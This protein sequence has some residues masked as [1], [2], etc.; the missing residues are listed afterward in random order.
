MLKN[1]LVLVAAA[2]LLFSVLLVHAINF[3]IAS[4]Q[5]PADPASVGDV[6]MRFQVTIDGKVIRPISL[7]KG[8]TPFQAAEQFCRTHGLMQVTKAEEDPGVLQLEA[9]LKARL[10]DYTIDEDDEESMTFIKVELD[11]QTVMLQHQPGLDPFSESR[12]F[13]EMKGFQE[14]EL[15]SCTQTL[16]EALRARMQ[17]N[18]QSEVPQDRLQ[19]L[20]SLPLMLKGKPVQLDYFVRDTP[21]ESAYQF[22]V[23][24]GLETDPDFTGYLKG[25]TAGI[26]DRLLRYSEETAAIQKPAMQTF[27]IPIS[28]NGVDTELAFA[29][30]QSAIEAA[31][32]FCSKPELKLRTMG[33]FESCSTQAEA[34][35]LSLRETSKAAPT[36]ADTAQA[37]ISGGVEVLSIPV[38]IGQ[39][40]FKVSVREGDT[41]T[42][43]ATRFCTENFDRLQVAMR[44][45]GLA[46]GISMEVCMEGTIDV[47]TRAVAQRQQAAPTPVTPATSQRQRLFSLNILLKKDLAPAVITFYEGDDP[48]EVAR[49]FLQEY[50]LNP[51]FADE[52][53]Q[54]LRERLAAIQANQTADYPE[55]PPLFSVPVTLREGTAPVPLMFFEGDEPG[56]VARAFVAQYGL[57]AEYVPVLTEELQRRLAG[58]RGAAAKP[59]VAADPLFTFEVLVTEGQPAIPL[60]YFEGELPGEVAKRFILEN[61]LDDS[62]Q[63]TITSAIVSRVRSIIPEEKGEWLFSLGVRQPNREEV[64]FNYY[65]KQDPER[66]V[67][68]FL[69]KNNFSNDLKEELLAA[70]L[71]MLE[72]QPRTGRT[73][74][75]TPPSGSKPLLTLPIVRSAGAEPVLLE[76]YEGDIPVQVAEAFLRKYD[77]DFSA[78]DA[79]V[80]AILQRWEALQMEQAAPQ[81]LGTGVPGELLFTVGIKLTEDSEAMSLP[82]RVGDSP[83][84]VAER[85][86]KENG[87]S[88]EFR[89]AI[90]QSIL[91]RV[92]R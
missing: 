81:D 12:A 79:L 37:A 35:I 83:I 69:A 45:S 46:P 2:G 5:L 17:Q 40:D 88:M 44:E 51:R 66:A 73:T 92:Q 67:A 86:L 41:A 68:E 58:V 62:L 72:E 53:A 31:R 48:L 7:K 90:V 75:Q 14:A 70:V 34:M 16:G 65:Q 63:E 61:G 28:V 3:E 33:A 27:R 25:L 15:D 19:P 42:T 59:T 38:E 24:N 49:S 91:A 4:E 6:L 22:L 30:E 78:K 56:A 21:A 32:A 13:C 77:I 60:S 89:E 76:V 71:R 39:F 20:F 36:P 1:I 85:F 52:I 26:E 84:L 82:V 8:Q 64:T 9:A 50:D 18:L 43:C 57:L 87:L 54:T 11:G 47:I 55:K 29:E 23:Q 80:Q 74:P 10:L